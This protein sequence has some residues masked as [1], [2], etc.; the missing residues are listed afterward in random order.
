MVEC[1]PIQYQ[2][3][4]NL[5][6]R[7]FTKFDKKKFILTISSYFGAK[8]WYLDTWNLSY[9]VSGHKS[10]STASVWSKTTLI[11]GGVGGAGIDSPSWK[12]FKFFLMP[13]ALSVPIFNKKSYQTRAMETFK[14]WPN[15]ECFHSSCPMRFFVENWHTKTQ[16]H[17]KNCP[18]F[19]RRNVCPFYSHTTGN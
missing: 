11:I 14:I 3:F 16:G 4:L 2:Y 15:F 1:K 7:N 17:K 18:H 19:I 5:T 6:I 12:T 13:L 9:T 10:L 8:N